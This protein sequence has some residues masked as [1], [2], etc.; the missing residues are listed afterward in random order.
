MLPQASGDQRQEEHEG[1]RSHGE[2]QKGKQELRGQKLLQI[3][4]LWGVTLLEANELH[5][6]EDWRQEHPCK[7]EE[8]VLVE[9]V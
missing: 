2:E 4:L 7:V 3:I 8:E 5:V 6:G 1:L 9:P